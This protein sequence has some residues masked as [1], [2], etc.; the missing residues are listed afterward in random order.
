MRFYGLAAL[1]GVLYFL[2]FA[3]FG[4]WPLAF[5]ALVP[6]LWVLE[7]EQPLSRRRLWGVGLTFGTVTKLGGYYWIGGTLERFSGF[8]FVVCVAIAVLLCAYEGLGLVLFS[9]LY[10]DARK[11]GARVSL[12][13]VCAMCLA[14]WIVPPLFPHFMGASLH[15]LP[16]AIQTADL[17]GP[18]LITGLLTLANA[19]VFVA[20]RGLRARRWDL[21]EPSIALGAWA[22]ALVYGAYRIAEVDAR[23]A[24]AKTLEMGLVQA[25]MG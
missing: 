1:S 2:G 18:L 4:I 6:M 7:P 24:S 5:V 21:R 22:L 3:G 13:A 10:R 8:P 14:E 20:V 23:V 9:F 12:A 11:R 15:M 25:D 19:G 16:L 17:G